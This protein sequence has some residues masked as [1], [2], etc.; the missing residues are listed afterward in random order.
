LH[1]LLIGRTE[2]GFD[3]LGYHCVPE[4]LAIA[5]K[6]LNNF[7]ERSTRISSLFAFRGKIKPPIHCHGIRALPNPCLILNQQVVSTTS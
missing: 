1:Q 7:V 2:R 5:Q 3:F 4:G 6:T